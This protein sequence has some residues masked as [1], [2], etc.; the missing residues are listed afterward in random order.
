MKRNQLDCS[1]D[2]STKEQNR[3]VVRYV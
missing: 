3:Y 2:I 1:I